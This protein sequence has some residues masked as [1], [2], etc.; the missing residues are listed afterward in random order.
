MQHWTV[1]STCQ[2]KQ[3]LLAVYIITFRIFHAIK[4]LEKFILIKTTSKQKNTKER[5]KWI[6]GELSSPDRIAKGGS[7]IIPCNN[8]WVLL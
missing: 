1:P 8:C 4:N 7:V 6:E 3:H 2:I 5:S